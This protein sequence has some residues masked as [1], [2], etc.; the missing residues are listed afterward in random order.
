MTHDALAGRPWMRELLHRDNDLFNR[1]SD[2]AQHTNTVKE[3]LELLNWR[4]MH[5]RGSGH[6]SRPG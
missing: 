5:G 2:T 1:F 6:P 4:E 3:A